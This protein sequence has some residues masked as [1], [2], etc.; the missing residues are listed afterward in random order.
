MVVGWI[1]PHSLSY[2]IGYIFFKCTVFYIF[3]KCLLNK[4]ALGSNFIEMQKEKGIQCIGTRAFPSLLCPEVPST[5][6][7]LNLFWNVCDLRLK[8]NH[9]DNFSISFS[10]LSFSNP[11]SL[12]TLTGL[13]SPSPLCSVVSAWLCR[14]QTWA[15]PSSAEIPALLCLSTAAAT[16]T[17]NPATSLWLHFKDILLQKYLKITLLE[18]HF[19]VF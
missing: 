10:V 11:G 2:F 5:N 12:Q 13:L 6:R 8:I 1:S 15:K 14:E 9:T 16:D 7:R 19:T 18:F 3:Q 17:S 4:I